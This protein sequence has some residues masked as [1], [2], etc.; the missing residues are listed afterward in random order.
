MSDAWNDADSLR[1]SRRGE[2]E[3]RRDG[4]SWPDRRSA[5]ASTR[6]ADRFILRDSIVYG[7]QRRSKDGRRNEADQGQMKVFLG[8]CFDAIK[9]GS[10]VNRLLSLSLIFSLSRIM[11]KSFALYVLKDSS[12]KVDFDTDVR[13]IE[14]GKFDKLLKKKV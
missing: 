2:V 9:S 3:K 14:I 10:R 6:R 13:L 5:A 11:R 1:S 7:R 4:A 8:R 12:L